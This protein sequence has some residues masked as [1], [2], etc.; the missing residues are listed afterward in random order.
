MEFADYLRELNLKVPSLGKVLEYETAVAS[1][2]ARII[3]STRVDQAT[4]E[5]KCFAA[6]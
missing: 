5:L 1:R 4:V 3:K 2:H 6:H